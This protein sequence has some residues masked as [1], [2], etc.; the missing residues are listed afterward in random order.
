M[1]KDRESLDRDN[2]LE[3]LQRAEPYIRTFLAFI[4]KL[5]FPS[6]TTGACYM[7]VD[8]FIGALKEDIQ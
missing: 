4:W 7:A 6:E 8:E 5:R 1:S 2:E 3:D